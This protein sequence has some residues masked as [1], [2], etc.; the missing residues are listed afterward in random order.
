MIDSWGNLVKSS[1][2]A[3]RLFGAGRAGFAAG[4]ALR[5]RGLAA[6]FLRDWLRFGRGRVATIHVYQNSEL[7]VAPVLP[8]VDSIWK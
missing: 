3:L 8:G 4:F 5:A 6:V 7:R 2:A 1:G